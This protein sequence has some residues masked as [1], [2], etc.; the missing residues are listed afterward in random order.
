ME[1]E[2]HNRKEIEETEKVKGILTEKKP[3]SPNAAEEE[4][5]DHKKK[6][7]QEIE[8]ERALKE[9]LELR[10]KEE[11]DFKNKGG[12]IWGNSS[13]SVEDS[14]LRKIFSPVFWVVLLLSAL[15]YIV[16]FVRF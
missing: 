11:D 6:I 8:A 7:A 2:L 10:F 1:L 9:E 15:V 12:L 5:V 4:Q 3:F 16:F 14:W 13:S